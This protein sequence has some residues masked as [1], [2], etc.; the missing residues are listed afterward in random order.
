MTHFNDGLAKDRVLEPTKL[1]IGEEFLLGHIVVFFQSNLQ[2]CERKG[3]TL[4]GS[5]NVLER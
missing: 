1:P 3:V 5:E 4:K 2:N